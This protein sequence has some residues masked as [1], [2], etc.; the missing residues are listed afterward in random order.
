MSIL[1]NIIES[2]KSD[3]QNR[4]QWLNLPNETVNEII[5]YAA[6]SHVPICY[7]ILLDIAKQSS[8]IANWWCI[9]EPAFWDST[10]INM[11]KST[12]FEL[13]VT[14]VQGQFDEQKDK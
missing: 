9:E 13:I 14:A 1:E 11:I 5:S 12:I 6:E 10:P 8:V 3:V 4:T 7:H 2:L